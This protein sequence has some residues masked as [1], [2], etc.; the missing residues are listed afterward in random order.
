[1]PLCVYLPVSIL[2]FFPTFVIKGVKYTVK[3]GLLFLIHL[4]KGF[5]QLDFF[6]FFHLSS[7]QLLKL[8]YVTELPGVGKTKF[9]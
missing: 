7:F 4:N 3:S 5:K 8:S 6:F 1:M 2:K 9:I